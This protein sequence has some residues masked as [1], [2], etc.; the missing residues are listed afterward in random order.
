MFDILISDSFYYTADSR[1]DKRKFL[2]YFFNRFIDVF[3]QYSHGCLAL[4]PF[5]SNVIPRGFRKDSGN[6][7]DI[8]KGGELHH[9][10]IGHFEGVS[11]FRFS[12]NFSQFRFSILLQVFKLY[13]LC[14]ISK[15]KMNNADRL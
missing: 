10:L 4:S 8:M 15:P 2:I 5:V 11:E 13:L 12:D 1:D 14:Y 3:S 6:F 9:D 7:L